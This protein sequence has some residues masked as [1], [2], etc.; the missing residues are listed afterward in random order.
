MLGLALRELQAALH[1]K[2]DRVQRE[3]VSMSEE[4][5]AWTRLE[6]IFS[7]RLLMSARC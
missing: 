1:E 4:L 7:M 5:D 3:F 2:A 6:E